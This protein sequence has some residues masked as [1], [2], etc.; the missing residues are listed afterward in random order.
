[1]PHLKDFI[2]E[3]GFTLWEKCFKSRFPSFYPK[4]SGLK[5]SAVFADP[6]ESLENPEI[7]DILYRPE[8]TT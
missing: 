7:G 6:F 3:S 4:L 2:Y 5:S 1:M 8:E